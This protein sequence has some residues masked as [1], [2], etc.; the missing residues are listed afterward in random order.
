MVSQI[1]ETLIDFGRTL[2][3]GLVVVSRIPSFFN[4]FISMYANYL[5]TSIELVFLIPFLCIYFPP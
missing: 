3:I 1:E 2:W 5:Q 4:L